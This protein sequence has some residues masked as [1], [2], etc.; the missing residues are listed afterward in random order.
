MTSQEKGRRTRVRTRDM[1][2]AVCYVIRLTWQADRRRLLGVLLT[3]FVTAAG[4][5]AFVL[6]TRDLLGGALTLGGDGETAGA[7]RLIPALAGLVVIGS[8][9]GVLRLINQA[10]QR[11]LG[12]KLDRRIIALV[13][14]S[15]AAAELATF[16][17]PAFHD[18][19]QRAVFASRS[20]P[21]VLIA[22]L[23]TV[24]QA[25]LGVLAVAG[26]FALMAWW[27]LPLCALSVLPI[28]RTARDE[29]DARYGLH[30]ELAEPRRVREYLERLLTGRDE[31]KE[32]R[33]FGL[34][35][36][37]RERWSVRYRSE[38]EQTA[39]MQGTHI[40]RRIV[41]RLLGDLVS[42]VVIGAVWLLVD[43]GG[44]TLSTGLAAL[45]ALWLLSTRVQML[46]YLFNNV[47]ET[48]LY[49]QDL[50]TFSVADEPEPDRPRAGVE[51]S[52]VEPLGGLCAERVGFGYPGSDRTVLH[53]VTVQL[54]RGEIVALVGPNGSGKTTLAK[55]LAGLYP[56]DTGRLVHNGTPVND[57]TPLREST[58]VVFQDFLRYKLPALDNIAF[59][60][61]EA[62]V[63]PARMEAAARQA[64][65]A[66]FLD[67]LPDGYDTVLSKE[68]TD[69]ADL[70]LG[71]WQRLALA[72][73]FYRNAPFVI[74]DEPT[75]SLDP[76]AEADLF[77]RIRELFTGRTVL[78]ISH[79]FSTVR[80]AD[81]IY[82]LDAGRVIE[83]GTH[84]SL[85]A[86]DGTYARLF[87]LQ[88]DAYRDA[89]TPTG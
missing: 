22:I 25:T 10:W 64:G 56:P 40:R 29:R 70:S 30:I 71:Q 38:I 37:L 88:A 4:L 6:L 24:L 33:A 60:R 18:R 49:L 14:R 23:S 84:E 66:E 62:P 58:A 26:A 80:S 32:V 89:R 16:E 34:G 42:V 73:A 63:D 41:A 79:R 50:R 52:V 46:G 61:P 13:L 67:S 65:A 83:H 11:I 77:S 47:G 86:E 74:L 1:V 43:N 85:I 45:T 51:V 39:T 76:Q 12:L 55:L 7:E 75:A 54:G 3:Q 53:E 9:S 5:G 21:M 31:A 68:F 19:L 27:L 69:G 28:L 72:R 82:V 78:L 87:H 59:G 20:Q 81:R 15:A 36:V 57:P 2:S 8:I 17:R 44:L 48:V 35:R